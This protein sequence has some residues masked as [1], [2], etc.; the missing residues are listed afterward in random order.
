MTQLKFQIAQLDVQAEFHQKNLVNPRDSLTE[1]IQQMRGDATEMQRLQS[2][3]ETEHQQAQKLQQKL[4][5]KL[6]EKT[7][8]QSSVRY[9]ENKY[10]AQ[11]DRMH[12][13]ERDIEGLR[14]EIVRLHLRAEAQEADKSSLQKRVD[15]LTAVPAVVQDMSSVEEIDQL[16]RELQGA[17]HRLSARKE[18]LLEKELDKLKEQQKCVICCE[19]VKSVL[20]LPCRHLCL[21][22]QCSQRSA[23]AQCPLCRVDISSRIDVFA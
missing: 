3:A 15:L 5:M 13:Q 19:R 12:T 18:T 7:I 16:S 10:K 23:M 4:E 6:A 14:A 20:L 8:L 2:L 11:V 1:A 9:W 21:C 17:L 22:Q